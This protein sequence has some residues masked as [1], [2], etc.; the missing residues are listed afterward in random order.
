MGMTAAKRAGRTIVDF[1]PYII[2]SLDHTISA[3]FEQLVD[4]GRGLRQGNDT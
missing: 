4:K 3:F 2:A 1:Q